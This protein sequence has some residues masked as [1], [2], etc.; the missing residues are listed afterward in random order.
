MSYIKVQYVLPTDAEWEAALLFFSEA[1]PEGFEQ[2]DPRD[3]LDRVG[4][5]EWDAH[6]FSVADLCAERPTLTA[7][8]P[9]EDRA[10]LADICRRW[11]AAGFSGDLTTEGYDLPPADAWQ[12]QF[13]P[14]VVTDRLEICP[15]WCRPSGGCAVVVLTDPGIGFGTG[16]DETTQLALRLLDAADLAGK[17]V[18]DVG[19]G[20]GILAVTAKKY[21]AAEVLAVDNDD[22]AVAAAAHLAALNAVELKS[23]P[24]DLLA[25]VPGRWDVILANIVTDVLLR[26][27]PTASAKLSPGGHL[28]LSGIHK[29]RLSD[30]RQAADAAGFVETRALTGQDWCGLGLKKG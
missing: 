23:Q 12:A 1:F 28:L 24:S 16:T 30:I 19:C 11:Q 10:G 21:G 5:D 6:E 26:L 17:R 4:G 8:W 7:Y 29:D 13:R 27:L 3:I 22:Q 20:S 25:Q 15:H 14:I 9:A 18:C 2:Y